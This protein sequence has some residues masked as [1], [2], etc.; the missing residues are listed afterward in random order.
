MLLKYGH[1]K[2]LI[3]RP[4][5]MR[6]EIVAYFPIVIGLQFVFNFFNFFWLFSLTMEQLCPKNNDVS[7]S[8]L[9]ISAGDYYY[10]YYYI[11]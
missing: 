3:Q 7:I 8:Q 10:H 2:G 11:L 9:S 4:L 1:G 5:L 6:G